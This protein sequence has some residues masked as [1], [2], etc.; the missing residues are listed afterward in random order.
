MTRQQ[1]ALRIIEA[2]LDTLE[3]EASGLTD[4]DSRR[5]RNAANRL[6]VLYGLLD[7]RAECSRPFP[8]IPELAP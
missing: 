2:S 3:E 1:T 8:A 4:A 5:L 7:L 6:K